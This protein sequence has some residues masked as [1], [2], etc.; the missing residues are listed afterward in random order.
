[1]GKLLLEMS[2]DLG[3]CPNYKTH[4]SE[5]A[6]FYL[7]FSD[8]VVKFIGGGSVIYGAYPVQFLYNEPCMYN[9]IGALPY[10]ARGTVHRVTVTE[11]TGVQ[12]YTT[13]LESTIIYCTTLHRIVFY[14]TANLPSRHHMPSSHGPSCPTTPN[15]TNAPCCCCQV[16]AK[17]VVYLNL[18]IFYLS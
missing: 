12:V 13:A 2:S 18:I 15:H 4:A 6:F 3:K 9:S 10:L 16:A 17:T 7:F 14:W 5:C 11:L 1:M 8:K